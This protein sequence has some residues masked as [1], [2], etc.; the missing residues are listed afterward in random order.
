MIDWIYEHKSWLFFLAGAIENI[1]FILE[2][3]YKDIYSKY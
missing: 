1:L 3:N 2:N